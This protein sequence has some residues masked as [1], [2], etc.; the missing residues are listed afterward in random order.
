MWVTAMNKNVVNTGKNRITR[1]LSLA[2]VAAM[3]VSVFPAAAF[4]DG[5]WNW[6]F[7]GKTDDAVDVATA[8]ASTPATAAEAAAGPEDI[9]PPM[10]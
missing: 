5:E 8:P 9:R 10:S 3:L 7:E 4:A 6:L 1:L 2:L